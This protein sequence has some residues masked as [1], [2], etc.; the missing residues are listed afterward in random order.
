M[1]RSPRPNHGRPPGKIQF[2]V[3]L[4]EEVYHT[5]RELAASLGYTNKFAAFFENLVVPVFG[6]DLRELHRRVLSAPSVDPTIFESDE[7]KFY[8]KQLSQAFARIADG[9]PP[10]GR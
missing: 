6:L 5:I 3:L 9:E 7:S 1:T 2:N 8:A 4:R 10:A